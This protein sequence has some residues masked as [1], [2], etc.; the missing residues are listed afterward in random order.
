MSRFVCR[1]TFCTYGPKLRTINQ[2]GG[3][4]GGGSI[5]FWKGLFTGS[6]KISLAE[7]RKLQGKSYCGRSLKCD[8]TYQSQLKNAT[9]T[10]LEGI[11]SN[12]I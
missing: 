2:R 9:P 4:G 6:P 11:I 8:A 1:N 12:L 10:S 7:P 3:G 5:H